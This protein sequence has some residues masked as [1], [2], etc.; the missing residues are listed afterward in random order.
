MTVSSSAASHPWLG[1]IKGSSPSPVFIGRSKGFASDRVLHR[2]P[3]PALTFPQFLEAIRLLAE[4]IVGHP[5]VLVSVETVMWSIFYDMVAV[6][7][8]LPK[9]KSLALS[10]AAS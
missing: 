4:D 10:K 2:Q 8:P 6:G 3:V 1:G 7:C 5:Q 9:E